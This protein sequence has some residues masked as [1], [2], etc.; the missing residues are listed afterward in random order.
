MINIYLRKFIIT[1]VFSITMLGSGYAYSFSKAV[2]RADSTK[3]RSTKITDTR[4]NKPTYLKNGVKVNFTPFKPEKDKLLASSKVAGIPRATTL[5]EKVQND[6]ILTNV[7]VYPNP[8]TEYLNMSY[9][10]S[11]DV[12]VTIRIMDILGNQITTLFSERLDAG[13]HTSSFSI[14]SKITS[15]F[16]FVRVSAG[17][18][19]ITK[20]ISVL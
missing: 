5:G 13:A 8:I 18:E 4:S 17:N 11:K 6:K 7:K 1:I 10:V 15:G 2:P 9:T 20:R 19:I 3:T 14:S 16:Y 12:N